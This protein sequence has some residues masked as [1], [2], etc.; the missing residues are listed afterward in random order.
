MNRKSVFRRFFLS[1]LIILLVPISIGLALYFVSAN[2]VKEQSIQLQ[3]AMQE[4]SVQ[5]LDS[6]LAQCSESAIQFSFDS[7]IM[8]LGQIRPDSVDSRDIVRMMEAKKK[9]AL[10]KME[11]TFWENFVI[12]F[13]EGGIFINKEY[14]SA[15]LAFFFED[16]L[17]YQQYTYPQWLEIIGSVRVKTVLPLQAVKRN[18]LSKELLTYMIPISSSYGESG[19][20]IC[21][22]EDRMLREILGTG[23]DDSS[24]ALILDAGGRII[25]SSASFSPEDQSLLTEYL[26]DES[27]SFE[28]R[29]SGGNMLGVYTQSPSSG[30]T[31]LSLTP[32]EIALGEVVLIRNITLLVGA[33]ALIVGMLVLAVISHRTSMPIQKVLTLLG[34]HSDVEGESQ[35]GL[36]QMEAGIARLI[37]TNETIRESFQR[38]GEI[39]HA[40]YAERLLNGAVPRDEDA[41]VLRREFPDF[42]SPELLC[43]VLFLRLGEKRSPSSLLR[44]ESVKLFCSTLLEELLPPE[45]ARLLHVLSSS[46]LA[47]VLTAEEKGALTDTIERFCDAFQARLT[48]DSNACLLGVGSYVQGIASIRDSFQAA[49]FVVDYSRLS[50]RGDSIFFFEDIKPS[51]TFLYSPHAE[52]QLIGKVRSGSVDETEKILEDIYHSNFVDNRLMPYM[53]KGLLYNLYCTLLKLSSPLSVEQS[54]ISNSFMDLLEHNNGEFASVFRE[55][56]KAFLKT[57]EQFASTKKSHNTSR[58]QQIQS[59]ISL[60]YMESDLDAVS[61]AGVFGIT[62]GY[63]S[64][65]F[66]EQTGFTFSSYLTNYRVSK[67]CALLTGTETAIAEVAEQVGYASVYS[68]RRAFK[69]VMGTPPSDYRENCGNGVIPFPSYK[70][71]EA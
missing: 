30:W 23:W 19:V 5:T 11:L 57:A 6:Y 9:M 70:D 7:D 41:A 50:D 45:S 60:H 36:N 66:K 61:I 22:L 1:Y 58:I 65:Y 14:V 4:K 26:S 15:E 20:L 59:Y 62:E 67:A 51:D 35:S 10:Y 52:L 16:M 3:H 48:G 47:V 68:F 39:L 56:Q 63:F 42:Q 49:R 40:L 21:L 34:Q 54:S 71:E 12:I 27:G 33:V 53:V 37:D 64:Q 46:E 69:R 31:Y 13:P 25:Y 28:D 55:M 44:I 43:C 17:C 2:V 29:F 18:G 32:T 8:A 24:T 38:Q